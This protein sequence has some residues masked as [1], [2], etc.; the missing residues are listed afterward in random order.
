[1]DT[2][3]IQKM[4][5]TDPALENA[6]ACDGVYEGDHRCVGPRTV[7]VRIGRV[8]DHLSVNAVR[9]GEFALSEFKN[10]RADPGEHKP[11]PQEEDF[12]M[13]IKTPETTRLPPRAR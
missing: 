1:M 4:S 6:A 9:R 3:R 12:H 8:A 11:H 13:C 7:T 2:N 5:G 10:Q